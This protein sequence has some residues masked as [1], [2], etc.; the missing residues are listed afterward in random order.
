VTLGGFQS[1]VRV[2]RDPSRFRRQGRSAGGAQA[3]LRDGGAG[4][5]PR[6]LLGRVTSS[7][8]RVRIARRGQSRRL[9]APATVSEGTDWK[10]HGEGHP[11]GTAANKVV[12]LM[13][14]RSSGPGGNPMAVA[15]SSCPVAASLSTER[16]FGN[17]ERS[18]V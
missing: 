8:S 15:T 5:G 13:T 2:A 16:R 11:P 18:L 7:L 9:L 17:I 6:E 10:R 4:G 12:A 1:A 3:S 14:S